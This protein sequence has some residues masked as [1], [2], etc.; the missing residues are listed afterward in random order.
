MRHGDLRAG[1]FGRSL[2]RVVS[3]P[4]NCDVAAQSFVEVS[5]PVPRPFRVASARRMIRAGTHI[6]KW[7]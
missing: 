3:L 7:L 6:D 1:L 4:W 5:V 2:E